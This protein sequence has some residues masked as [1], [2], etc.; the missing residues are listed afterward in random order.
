[1]LKPYATGL[2]TAGAELAA[3]LTPA[4]LDEVIALVPDEWLAE[5]DFDSADE[6]RSAYL[7]HLVARAAEPAAWLPGVAS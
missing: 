7:G 4:V 6:A 2:A 5:F 1:V 3:E